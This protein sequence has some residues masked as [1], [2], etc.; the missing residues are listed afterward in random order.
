MTILAKAEYP[1]IDVV[2]AGTP[3]LLCKFPL[4]CIDQIHNSLGV[5]RLLEAAAM[6]SSKKMNLITLP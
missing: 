2:F 1:V 6:R 5:S 3:C 4:P